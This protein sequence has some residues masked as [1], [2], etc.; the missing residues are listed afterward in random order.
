[1]GSKSE[2]GHTGG[3]AYVFNRSQISTN[4]ISRRAVS[5]V[6][7]LI[8]TTC[9]WIVLNPSISYQE[10]DRNDYTTKSSLAVDFAGGD[11][12]DCDGYNRSGADGIFG[13]PGA[14][15]C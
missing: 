5:W 12:P 4:S 15:D 6:W 2:T 7:F 9:G 13:C 3:F 11:H 8:F 10:G 1:M 14:A